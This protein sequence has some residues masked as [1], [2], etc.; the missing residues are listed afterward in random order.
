MVHNN[1]NRS[2]DS[3]DFFVCP[4]RIYNDEKGKKTEK[5]HY[6]IGVFVYSLKLINF[7]CVKITETFVTLSQC[8]VKI[9][10]LIKKESSWRYFF[11]PCIQHMIS[12]SDINV[13]PSVSVLHV[14]QAVTTTNIL[15]LTLILYPYEPTHAISTH[16]HMHG[17]TYCMMIL[18]PSS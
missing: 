17:A 5:A 14:E 12:V 11:S 10:P 13:K 9:Y 4:V 8:I 16:S 3:I 7:V 15:I 18:K 2:D 1:G 6:C